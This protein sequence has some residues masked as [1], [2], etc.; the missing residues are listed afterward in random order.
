MEVK[1]EDLKKGKFKLT[2]TVS[3]SEM[4][5]YF[6][7]SY[8]KIAPTIK[9]DGFR[10]GK[11]P[12]KL[13]ESAAGTARI[14]SEALDM[15]ISENYYKAIVEKNLNPITQPK[16]VVN[17]YPSYGDS[18]DNVKDEFEFE[19]EIEILP[20]VLLGDYKQLKVKA[21]GVDKAKKEDIEKVLKHFQKQSATFSEIDRPA[22]KGDRVEINFE[23][24][25]K[26]VR[27]DQMCSKNHPLILG[28]GNLIPGFEEEIVGMK[29]GEKK[30][31]KITFPKD[32]N[33]KDYAGKEA[34]F[35]IELVDLKEVKLPEFQ[36][37][38]ASKFGHK[39]MEELKKAVEKN[40]NLELEEDYKRNIEAEVIEKVLTKLKVEIPETLVD[41]EAERIF[42]EFSQQ[43]S[44]QGINIERYLENIKKTKEE[45]LKDMR[46]QAEKNVKTG[47]LLGKIIEENK[48]D[49]KDP[50]S[51]EKAINYL[52]NELTK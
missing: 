17:K 24:F 5:G 6:N 23:G 33:S 2:I 28:E 1:S 49:S 9:L 44:S 18:E 37:D 3:S 45:L 8:E 19:A 38:F 31:F 40:L 7:K 15:A 21:R 30:E 10:P 34:E 25:L 12:R 35:K 29:K 16:I 36:D 13:V 42:G 47:L 4:V 51:G 52:V 22:K 26:K 20:P 11:A 39:N 14:L 48:W 41:R 50:K 32:Y 43:I 27:V 46:P